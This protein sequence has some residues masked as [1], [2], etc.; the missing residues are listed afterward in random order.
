[1]VDSDDEDSDLN[2]KSNSSSEMS[3]YRQFAQE[4][5]VGASLSDKCTCTCTCITKQVT[6]KL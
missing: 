6:I 4:I 1:M 2:P 3:P 5:M